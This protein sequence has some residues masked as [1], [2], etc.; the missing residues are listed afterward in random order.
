MKRYGFDSLDDAQILNKAFMILTFPEPNEHKN[1]SLIKEDLAEA[2]KKLKSA[3][4]SNCL[5]GNKTS[6]LLVFQN[7]LFSKDGSKVL[8]NTITDNKYFSSLYYAI[9]SYYMTIYLT[10]ARKCY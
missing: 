3:L 7:M 4:L 1:N 6:F 2:L 10:V 9:V 5:D 8:Q